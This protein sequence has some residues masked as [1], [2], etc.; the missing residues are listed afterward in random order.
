MMEARGD[1]GGLFIGLRSGWKFCLVWI[2][3]SGWKPEQPD[4]RLLPLKL[5]AMLPVVMLPPA[6]L[7]FTELLL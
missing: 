2:L 5:F 7:L 6:V 1:A 3:G 4:G